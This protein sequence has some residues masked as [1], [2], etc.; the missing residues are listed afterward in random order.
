MLTNVCTKA[1]STVSLKN[2]LK[3]DD[4]SF[5]LYIFTNWPEARGFIGFLSGL[6]ELGS[7][8]WNLKSY[9]NYKV[10]GIFSM[11][12]LNGALIGRLFLFSPD[13]HEK[14]DLCVC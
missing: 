7:L 10:H 3:L 12:G 5:F 11:W 14:W 13:F 6:D 2:G 9:Y 1:N 4:F 8:I